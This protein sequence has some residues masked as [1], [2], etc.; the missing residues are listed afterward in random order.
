M[1]LDVVFE[2]GGNKT[3]VMSRSELNRKISEITGNQ[4]YVLHL[5]LSPFNTGN[6]IQELQKR[7]EKLL[8]QMYGEID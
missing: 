6:V 7:K 4:I 2:D 3:T 1:K 8:K 5:G